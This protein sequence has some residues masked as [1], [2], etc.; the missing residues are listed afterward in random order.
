MAYCSIMQYLQSVPLSD[1]LRN[2]VQMLL[3]KLSG[4]KP[5]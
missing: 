5:S 4:V 3:F 1:T 2:T